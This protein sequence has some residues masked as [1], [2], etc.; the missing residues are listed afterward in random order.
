MMKDTEILKL[1]GRKPISRDIRDLAS[2][3]RNKT[4]LV[5]G[6]AGSIGSELIRVLSD[7][8]TK[9]ICVDWWE[10]GVFYLQQEIKEKNVVFLIADAK[11]KSMDCVLKKYKPQ[12]VIHAAAY[13]HVPLMQANPLEA[14]NNNLKGTLNMMELA[15]KYE[16][17]NFI[18]VSTDKA[19]RPTNVMGATKR[20]CELMMEAQSDI[21]KFNAVRF[22]NVIQSN[23][24]V[25]NTFLRQIENGEDVTVTHKNITRYFMTRREAVELILLTPTIANGKDIFLLDMGEPVRIYDLASQLIKHFR[26]KSRIVITGLRPGEKMT[27]E[28]GY[29]DRFMQRTGEK[30]I[31]I[32]NREEG[33]K[34]LL[35]LKTV[36][37]L[38][39]RT[40]NYE[41]DSSRL[42]WYLRNMGFEIKK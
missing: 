3:Y 1:L 25:V 15:E 33:I 36:K 19:V 24:S 29:D 12:I 26:S 22:G 23:G 5:T 35:A 32:V 8:A 2:F 28:L 16:V 20:I 27:E 34:P 38:L 11:T 40:L 31:Y 21:V 30:K 37:S 14:F 7:I 9:V 4:V 10:N 42:K 13:K 41:I 39:P 6:G 17:E 18:L